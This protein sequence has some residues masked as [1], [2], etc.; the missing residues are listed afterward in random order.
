[1]KKLGSLIVEL[2]EVNMELSRHY[3]VVRNWKRRDELVI[4]LNKFGDM[5]WNPVSAMFADGGESG[6]CD[7]DEVCTCQTQ[8]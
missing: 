3:N 7:C 5:L 4:E 6:V 8:S 2:I 1:M